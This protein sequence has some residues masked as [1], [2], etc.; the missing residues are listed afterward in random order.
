MSRADPNCDP[1][2]NRNGNTRSNS[3]RDA[4]TERYGDAERGAKR[5]TITV[6][7]PD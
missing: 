2:A 7:E 5:V 1:G 6:P 4:D 3:T